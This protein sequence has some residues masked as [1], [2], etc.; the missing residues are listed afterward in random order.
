MRW[1]HEGADGD[2][3][4]RAEAGQVEGSSRQRR[5]ALYNERLQQW[6]PANEGGVVEGGVLNAHLPTTVSEPTRSDCDCWVRALVATGG[7]V[8]QRAARAASKGC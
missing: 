7:S 2:A 5:L 8:R 1:A 6:Q 3:L 4:E